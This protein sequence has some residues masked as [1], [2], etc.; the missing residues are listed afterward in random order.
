[1]LDD[2]MVEAARI[3]RARASAKRENALLIPSDANHSADGRRWWRRRE[4]NPRPKTC[5]GRRYRL[6][7]VCSFA[8]RIKTGRKRAALVRLDLALL[9]RTEGSEPARIDDA[10]N[11]RHGRAEIRA[12]LPFRQPEPS[13]RWH[14]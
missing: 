12:W 13:F 3:D 1:M 9:P 2:E 11:P 4:L 5:P 14:F 7:P 10:L 6:S 8:L